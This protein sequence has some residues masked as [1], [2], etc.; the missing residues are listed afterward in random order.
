MSSNK[1]NF[2]SLTAAAT[3]AHTSLEL[4][5]MKGNDS[6]RVTE[7]GVSLSNAI[8]SEKMNRLRSLAGAFGG[9]SSYVTASVGAD[10]QPT[11]GLSSG[12]QAPKIGFSWI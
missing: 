2:D 4:R 11:N 7:V 6:A 5:T 3:A 12:K 8:S 10:E 1:N 9:A